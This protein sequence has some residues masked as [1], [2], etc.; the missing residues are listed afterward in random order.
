M[1][2]AICSSPCLLTRSG[3]LVISAYPALP[4]GGVLQEQR[5]VGNTHIRS[6]NWV[7]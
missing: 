4:D 1:L 2:P 3:H 7:G 5:A 6:A